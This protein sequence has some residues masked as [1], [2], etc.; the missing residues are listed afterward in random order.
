MASRDEFF[1]CSVGYVEETVDF[2]ALN[3]SSCLI[4]IVEVCGY[5][6][7]LEGVKLSDE[8]A[9]DGC[10]VVIHHAAGHVFGL[11]FSE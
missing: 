11:S 5:F 8:C 6:C 2:V 9:A 7:V 3:G 10:F 1:G 4:G